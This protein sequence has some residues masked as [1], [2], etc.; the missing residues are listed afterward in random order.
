M[1]NQKKSKHRIF[2]SAPAILAIDQ[3]TT[4]TKVLIVDEKLNILSECS[5]EFKQHYPKPGWVEHDL[6]EI[7]R[8]TISAIKKAT[9]AK[10]VKK[11]RISAI[12]ITNQRETVCFW[13][14]RT[15]KPLSKAIVWQDRRTTEFCNEMI[16]DGLEPEI[17]RRTGLIIDPY[18]SASKIKWAL[19]NNKSIRLAA[20]GGYLACGTIDSYLIAKLT[21]NSSHFTEPSNASRTLLFNIETLTWDEE[22][23]K[24]FKVPKDCLPQVLDSN[25]TF[26]HTEGVPGLEN[27]IPIQGV[28]GDQ[29]AALLGQACVNR[30]MAK[31]T[32]GT[33]SFILM[34]TGADI[35]RS[36][37]RQLST[38]AWSIN[39]KAT[40]ALEGGAFTAG[41]AV[42]W[43]RDGL[44]FFKKS[45]DV[46]KLAQSVRSS[47]GVVFV[48]ALAG[49]GAPHWAPA[50]RGAFLG[51]TRGTSRGHM[52]RAVLEGIA[53]MN[54]DILRAME[55]DLGAPLSTL[56][57]DGGA[58]KNNFLMQYQSDLLNTKLVRPKTVHT[59]SMGAIFIAG[60]GFGLWHS[61]ED[62]QRGWKQDKLFR[63]KISNEDRIKV[64]TS[65][66]NAVKA[67]KLAVASE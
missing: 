22:L 42:Q 62:I 55:N 9:A 21:K 11:Y 23:L 5:V 32:Y 6:D 13:N 7:W 12:G 20:D 53:L 19:E 41:A 60:L 59:T 35:K 25:G 48:P 15:G 54:F 2:N 24:L 52:A 65:W 44:A 40:Y 1:V 8:S 36:R 14:K 33:G 63:P 34:N 37:H 64:I 18:F 49:L 10:A 45:E 47:D 30:G 29:Q 56:A 16:K 58:S 26:G 51:L 66:Q 38:V 3:G 17:S 50:A 57:V 46:E 31:C 43:L 39:G 4:G 67:V 27:G 61:L 28:L